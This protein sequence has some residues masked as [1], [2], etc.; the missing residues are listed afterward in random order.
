MIRF[1]AAVLAALLAWT[2]VPA[3]AHGGLGGGD[4]FLSGAL[5]PFIAVEHLI[6][7]LGLGLL[8]GR[9]S[10]ERRGL[11]FAFLGIGLVGGAVSA[12]IAHPLPT[13]TLAVAILGLAFAIGCLVSL[14]SYRRL[15]RVLIAALASLAG[16]AVGLDTD[17]AGTA[18]EVW[19][20]RL[21]PMLGLATGVFL[22]VLDAAALSSIAQRPPFPVVVRVA[23]S[24]IAAVGLML[25]AL[26]VG[27]V[28]AA[29]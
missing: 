22:I 2:A 8:S 7:L 6:L 26:L 4:G 20:V 24:W 3:A 21:V 27:P 14:A 5:H 19:S 1:A 25:L 10:M 17:L 29:G 12:Q 16:L 18:Q 28:R 13:R 23:G 15:P 11:S 9:L